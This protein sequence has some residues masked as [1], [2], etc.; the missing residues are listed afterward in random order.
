MVDGGTQIFIS[1]ASVDKPRIGQYILLLLKWT[2]NT[3]PEVTLW[4]DRPNEILIENFRAETG[5]PSL[6]MHPRVRGISSA[7][8]WLATILEGVDNSSAVIVFWSD[9]ARPA[10]KDVF[11]SEIL[12]AY[13]N[14]KAFFV[15]L[16]PFDP[17]TEYDILLNSSQI[18][19]VG[20]PIASERLS[21][22]HTVVRELF[23]LVENDRSK[24]LTL[25]RLRDVC[26]ASLRSNRHVN[27]FVPRLALGQISAFES[28]SRRCLAIVGDAGKGKTEALRYLASINRKNTFALFINARTI[29]SDLSS[30]IRGI[31]G[32]QGGDAAFD[33]ESVNRLLGSRDLSLSIFVDALN[34][35][36]ESRGA[37]RKALDDLSVKQID[38]VKIFVTCRTLDWDYWITTPDGEVNQFGLSVLSV[39]AI[40]QCVVTFGDYSED[41]FNLAYDRYSS[42]YNL[43]PIE[44]PTIRDI[45]KEPFMLRAFAETYKNRRNIPEHIEAQALVQSYITAR[46][47]TRNIRTA[48]ERVLKLIAHLAVETAFSIVPSTRLADSD[49]RTCQELESFGILTIDNNNNVTFRY[50]IVLEYYISMILLDEI[51]KLNSEREVS[52]FLIDRIEAGNI[53]VAPSVSGLLSVLYR[54]GNALAR[55]CTNALLARSPECQVIALNHILACSNVSAF[56]TPVRGAISSPI[57]AV[58]KLSA[59]VLS[60][61]T[62]GFYEA[63]L[64]ETTYF[65]DVWEA[66][67]T[68]ANAI[69][70]RKTDNSL[71][72]TTDLWELGLHPHWRVRRASGYAFRAMQRTS[73]HAREFVLSKI[74][75]E[76]TNDYRAEHVICIAATYT[77]TGHA[78]AL[79]AQKCCSSS[80]DHTRWVAAHY[81]RN[82]PKGSIQGIFDQ[83]STDP[84]PWVRA[85]LVE[86]VIQLLLGTPGPE[87]IEKSRLFLSAASQ[88][89]APQI[90]L[91]MARHLEKLHHLEWSRDLIGAILDRAPSGTALHDAAQMT[92]FN[93][94]GASGYLDLSDE[95]TAVEN[96]VRLRIYNKRSVKLERDLALAGIPAQSDNYFAIADSIASVLLQQMAHDWDEQKLYQLTNL[97]LED[98]DET[99]RWAFVRFIEQVPPSIIPVSKKLEILSKLSNDQHF[100]VRREVAIASSS[101]DK[102]HKDKA[103]AIMNSLIKHSRSKA[104]TAEDEV[105]YFAERSLKRIQ[106]AN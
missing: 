3:V 39:D 57:S 68:V 78:A 30:E 32:L 98:D 74:T 5:Y 34:E 95:R 94:N 44:N 64:K 60:R 85:K 92:L 82:F 103:I 40:G 17:A 97:L 49:F 1:H 62:E 106:T 99:V 36:D 72:L 102:E 51:G 81:L 50:E 13:K 47:P 43:L 58:R 91:R 22:F 25:T 75:D 73:P 15:S 18:A 63:V 52:I 38:R 8:E 20:Q 6:A 48:A 79:A 28:S 11:S 53:N 105:V 56:S 83:L 7:A 12:H 61:A 10:K 80:H 19:F 29:S 65:D 23:A 41:E 89:E 27:V 46:L 42:H 93:M 71:V 54:E 76:T 84:S 69:G 86:V 31:L 26:E 4:I 16:D 90:L 2:E 70:M 35:A 104:D 45:C 88:K 59:L 66:K 37:L 96:A 100:W 21:A 9:Q 101:I 67:E 77:N 87:L 14:D 55:F 33:V 24:K